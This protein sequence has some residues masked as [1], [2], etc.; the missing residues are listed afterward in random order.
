MKSREHE[1]RNI[2]A[3]EAANKIF[4]IGLLANQST[5]LSEVLQAIV[6]RIASETDASYVGISLVDRK[7]Q[8]IVHKE[9]VVREG[10]PTPEGHTQAIGLGVVGQV[11]ATGRPFSLPDVS[12]FSDYISIVPGMRSELAV[13]LKL[14]G[15]VIG[16][17]NLESKELEK[18]G[19]T[20]KAMLQA[21]ATPIAQAVRSA[22]LFHTERRRRKQLVLLNQVGSII[23][24]TITLDELLQRACQSIRD[25]LGYGFVGICLVDEGEKHI[26][27]SAVAAEGPLKISQGYSQALGKGVV[28]EV[29]LTGVSLLVPDVRQRANYVSVNDRMLSEMCCPLKAGGKII[30]CLDAEQ[31][32]AGSFDDQDLL[33]FETLAEHL[34]HA[35]QNRRNLERIAQ[36]KNDLTGMIVHDLRSPVTVIQSTLQLLAT[37]AQTSAREATEASPASRLTRRD[38]RS[39]IQHAQRSCDEMLVLIDSL[40]E[41]QRLESGELQLNPSRCAPGD[42][43][44][45]VAARL[46]VI[47]ESR[48]IA[49]EAVCDDD[50]PSARL[51]LDLVSRILQNLV[52]NALK[53]TPAG[54][55]VT[56]EV[57]SAP[58]SLLAQRLPEVERGL[59]FT[60]RDTGPGIPDGEQERIFE[61]FGVVES[62]KSGVKVSTGLGLAF[63]KEAV[64]AH[65]GKIWV[66]SGA[67][68]GSAFRVLLPLESEE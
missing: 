46:T 13:P 64:K 65:R 23:N 58:D 67:D 40:L 14:S 48:E 34:S 1:L 7:R 35:I 54:G 28:G 16:V 42:M 20:T 8:L 2:G 60:V 49:L 41:L 43:P 59:V 27:L 56:V 25:R 26:T 44:R 57:A 53:F 10:G 9:C 32:A 29:A 24:T 12:L 37:Q 22:Q 39:Y 33:L 61:K 63:C 3:L 17:V 5:D 47:A 66:E 38:P 51:D 18:F 11:V 30:G 4:E 6:D 68:G 50:L 45:R 19:A 52:S 55:R 62:R 15:E 36:L 31:A 21:L